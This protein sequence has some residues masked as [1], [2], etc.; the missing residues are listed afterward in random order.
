[1]TPALVSVFGVKKKFNA[2]RA[3][4]QPLHLLLH[5]LDK[6]PSL[7]QL[8]HERRDGLCPVCFLPGMILDNAG[9]EVDFQ[10]IPRPDALGAFGALKDRQTHIEGIAIED[11]SKA[12]GDNA[13]DPGGF[14][15]YRGVFPR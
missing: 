6:A 8:L 2:N 12:Q 11:P 9:I 14:Y 4:F 13:T 10:F 15:G 3:L 1:L 7:D 5:V